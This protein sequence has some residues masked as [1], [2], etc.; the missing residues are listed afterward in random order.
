[1]D[2]YVD[3]VLRP[4]PEFS[5]AQLMNALF[6]KLHRG[7]V[8]RAAQGIGVSFPGVAP[9]VPHLGSCLRVH[10][11]ESALVALMTAEWL[12]GI[13]DH[14]EVRGPQLVP[15][16][17]KHRVVRRVQAQSNPA[18]LR[19]RLQRRQGLS[20]AETLARIP[21]A[22]GQMLSLPYVQLRSTSTGQ[23]FRL[24]VEHGELSDTPVAGTFSAYGL[25]QSATVPWF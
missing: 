25:S 6:A 19:R 3:L 10:G 17:A 23:N 2:H 14:V 16:G 13:R 4:D 9:K 15:I 21:D 20:D 1:M 7:L 22:V 8:Q 12:A 24:F 5:A 18:R 11:S